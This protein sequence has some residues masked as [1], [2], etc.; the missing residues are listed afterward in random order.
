M[1]TSFSIE[2]LNDWTF[3][4][5]EMVHS[6]L[7]ALHLQSHSH[8][9]PQNPFEFLKESFLFKQQRTWDHLYPLV[10]KIWYLTQHPNIFGSGTTNPNL[11]HLKKELELNFDPY[12]QDI[13]GKTPV[14]TLMETMMVLSPV[15]MIMGWKLQQSQIIFLTQTFMRECYLKGWKG[16]AL[17]IYGKKAW[18]EWQTL[19]DFLPE[20]IRQ[21]FLLIIEGEQEWI[22]ISNHMNH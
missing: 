15:Q 11:I 19:Q 3:Q 12:T 21:N 20:D 22:K 1:N 4:H 5:E 2:Q 6:I 13:A 8:F 18:Q 14:H 17:D 7:N 16:D 9:L 10:W